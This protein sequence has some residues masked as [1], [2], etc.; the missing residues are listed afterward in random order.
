MRRFNLHERER[1]FNDL[2]LL[3]GICAIAGLAFSCAS[4]K[5]VA[6]AYPSVSTNRIEIGKMFEV[7]KTNAVVQ[8]PEPRIK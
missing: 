8:K 3:A 5:S 2:V 7:P 1:E 4:E 6:N